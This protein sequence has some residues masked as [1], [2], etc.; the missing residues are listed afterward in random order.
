M[1]SETSRLLSWKRIQQCTVR[2][3][4]QIMTG[5]VDLNLRFS[6]VNLAH[7]CSATVNCHTFMSPQG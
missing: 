1:P 6:D 3:S 4:V 2:I 5:Q 7:S